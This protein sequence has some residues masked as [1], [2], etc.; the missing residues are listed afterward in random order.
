MQKYAEDEMGR[1]CTGFFSC[2]CP[3]VP[4]SLNTQPLMVEKTGQQEHEASHR[5]CSQEAEG[6]GAQFTVS[7]L[8]ALSR[9]LMKYR[10]LRLA[11]V[12]PSLEFLPRHA[13][14]LG[15]S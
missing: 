1:E 10:C 8:F 14:K 2:C 9:L 11:W 3:S 12:F 15:V 5:I 6:G 4:G 7:F 13:Q